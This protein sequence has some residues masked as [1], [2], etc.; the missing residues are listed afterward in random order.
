VSSL[1]V[2]IATI[3]AVKPHPN[4][5]RLEIA[6][7]KGWQVV[8][9]RGT[10]QPGDTVVY[11]PPD[12]VVP[13]EWSDKWDVTKYLS[14][15]RVRC[16]KLRGEPSFG[17]TVSLDHL[18]HFTPS[19]IGVGDNVAD[20]FGITKY[21]PPFKPSTEDAAPDHPLFVK[22][23]EIE[24]LR[25]FPDVLQ[26]GEEVVATE[27]IHGG[28]VRVG[29]IDGEM[30][31]GSHRL[32]RK[33]PDDLSSSL[34]WFP[35]TQPGVESLLSTLGADHKQV[36]LYGEVYGRVQSLHYGI[37]NGVAFRA[38]DLLVD[39]KY[40]DWDAFVALC[41][42]HGVP[43]VP[44]V[45]RGP[46]SLDQIKADSEGQTLVGGTHYREGVVVH[47]VVERHDERIGRTILKYVS[48][49]YLLGGKDEPVG[50]VDA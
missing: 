36:V 49:T 15:G 11:V 33:R 12:A 24:N 37:E 17:F 2:P 7:I 1:I 47:P 25:H 46:F 8:V 27:K 48:D 39:G 18:P 44:V 35:L 41:T 26:D 28:N 45:Y 30:M 9:G 10:Y 38:F 21:E 3:D 19:E 4:A 34:Y 23:T 50:A 6:T 16:A 43:T 22:Y 20:L 29:V 42:L 13:V 14:K 31:A 5:D 40:L 32:R